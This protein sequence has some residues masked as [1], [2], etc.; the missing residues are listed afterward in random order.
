MDGGS[1]QIK[2]R[3]KKTNNESFFNFTHYNLKNSL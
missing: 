2:E 3:G 1:W